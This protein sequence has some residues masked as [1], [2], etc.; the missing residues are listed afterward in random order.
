[1]PWVDAAL[2]L[3]GAG[4]RIDDASAIVRREILHH[5]RVAEFGVHFHFSEMRREAVARGSPLSCGGSGV[6]LPVRTSS[7]FGHSFVGD[8]LLEILH[9]LDHRVAGMRR[10]AAAGFADRIGANFGV[11]AD[12]GDLRQ[13]HAQFLRGDQTP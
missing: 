4:Q 3:A 2:H 12:D 6:A 5:A 9:R 7:P 11:A 8:L 10:G 1:M 13:R